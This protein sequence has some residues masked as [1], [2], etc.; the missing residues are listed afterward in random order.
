[1]AYKNKADKAAYM[2]KLRR[3]PEYKAKEKAATQRRLAKPEVKAKKAAA[4]K[5]YRAKPD[6]RE[7]INEQAREKYKS[8]PEAQQA[9]LNRAA[10]RTKLI[11]RLNRIKPE[12]VAVYN[13]IEN[14]ELQQLIL[15]QAKDDLGGDFYVSEGHGFMSLDSLEDPDGFIAQYSR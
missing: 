4:E 13:E 7:R 15:E 2:R 1:M 12:V 9:A 8:S 14:E 6:V 10:R 5:A 3:S 11:N